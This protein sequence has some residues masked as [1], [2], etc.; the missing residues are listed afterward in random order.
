[1]GACCQKTKENPA[2]QRVATVLRWAM[3]S[4]LLA[5]MPKC[6]ACVVAYVALLTG[7]GISFTSAWYLQTGLILVCLAALVYL[8][9]RRFEAIAKLIGIWRTL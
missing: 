8:V 6:P 9:V 5:V 1:M 4:V 3:P 2:W 7:V